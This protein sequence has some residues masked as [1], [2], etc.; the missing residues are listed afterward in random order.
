V[1]TSIKAYAS[2]EEN[3]V[4]LALKI[5]ASSAGL[6]VLVAVLYLA[7]HAA[8]PKYKVVS[9]GQ[10]YRVLEKTW[11]SYASIPDHTSRAML[12]DRFVNQF[13]TYEET[14]ELIKWLQRDDS[15]KT[16]KS[17]TGPVKKNEMNAWLE[18][19]GLDPEQ[20]VPVPASRCVATSTKD[21]IVG[22]TEFRD[23]RGER[24][25]YTGANPD[26]VNDYKNWKPV[27]K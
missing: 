10:Y 9:N 11:L 27:P 14:E 26:D 1:E 15:D 19:D 5:L 25:V 7:A 20:V 23:I 2:S 6:V 3:G 16:W 22:K 12:G 18:G 24:W 21:F 17:V 8:G 13:Q 4:K